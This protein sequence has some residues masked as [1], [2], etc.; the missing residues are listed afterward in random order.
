MYN[1]DEIKKKTTFPMTDR[2]QRHAHTQINKS[3]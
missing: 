2:T 1:H 3:I